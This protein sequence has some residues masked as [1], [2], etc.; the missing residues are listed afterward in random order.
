[1]KITTEEFISKATKIHGNK[2]DY[3][4]VNYSK[5]NDPVDIVCPIHG[6]FHQRPH[7]HLKGCGCPECALERT[8]F[9]RST[10][11]EFI[12]KAK[13][14]HG[15]KYDYSKVNYVNNSTNVTIICPIHGEFQQ[16]P[17]SHLSG[18]GC[19]EC[20]KIQKS[21]KLRSTTEDF[22]EKAKNIYGDKYDYSRTEYTRS[23]DKVT[24]ICPKHGEFLTDPRNF[25]SGHGCYKCGKESMAS[26]SRMT[27]EEF[28][29]KAKEVHGDKYDYSKTVYGTNS[30]DPVTITCLIHGDFL[31][32][33]TNHLSGRGCPE[34]GKER[35]NQLKKLT[36]EKFIQRAKEIHGNRYNYDKSVYTSTHDKITITCPIHG[37][38]LQQPNVHLT[39]HGCPECAKESIGQ[40]NS[41]TKEEFIQRAIEVH[42]DKYNYDKVDYHGVM[43]EVVITCPIHG[44]F[45]QKPSNHLMGGGCHCCK[46][47]IGEKDV[48]LLLE[49]HGVEFSKDKFY[50]E[51]TRSSIDF[52]IPELNL[53]IEVQGAQHLMWVPM[54]QRT[55]DQFYSQVQRDIDKYRWAER[56]EIPLLYYIPN[57]YPE[58][59]F[60]DPYFQGIY[61]PYN[62]FFTIKDLEKRFLDIKQ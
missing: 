48:R 34:C 26:I 32:K 33:P 59:L 50:C 42:G 18:K 62:T 13:K 16:T 28:I 2:Y 53:F 14:V 9:R 43:T 12:E 22:V 20:S 61:K 5:T 31:Q 7:E 46:E 37:D 47:S 39:N 38:F 44:D 8:A 1:M 29:E 19:P 6:V 60:T 54:F 21:L 58:D 17:N 55:I 40:K 57:E 30:S 41:Y 15:N 35:Q 27:T 36:T 3:S 24:V 45:L 25:L 56:E 52:K 49:K 10:T 11:E 4:L 51:S 23:C